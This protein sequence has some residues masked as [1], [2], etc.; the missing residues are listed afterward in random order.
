MNLPQTP[1]NRHIHYGIDRF[2]PGTCTNLILLLLLLLPDLTASHYVTQQLHHA[3]N[4]PAQPD[5]PSADQGVVPGDP[6]SLHVLPARDQGS[7]RETGLLV[8]LYVLQRSG[9][10][11]HHMIKT[12]HFCKLRVLWADPV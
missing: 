1:T 2:V 10:L 6:A 12:G 8:F 5:R 9:Q 4:G 7:L 11:Y 3:R